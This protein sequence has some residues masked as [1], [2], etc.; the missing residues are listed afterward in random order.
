M[1]EGYPPDTSATLGVNS[2]SYS[3]LLISY[4][5]SVLLSSHHGTA[6]HFSRRDGGSPVS[7]PPQER[8]GFDSVCPEGFCMHALRWI[9][10]WRRQLRAYDVKSA[11]VT[12]PEPRFS[13]PL[14]ERASALASAVKAV[15]SRGPRSQTK[16]IYLFIFPSE[17]SWTTDMIEILACH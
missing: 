6:A 14:M 3:F 5:F 12:P 10:R 15:M 11:P 9:N 8:T 4:L 2:V 1:N 13:R 7:P 16:F 17:P